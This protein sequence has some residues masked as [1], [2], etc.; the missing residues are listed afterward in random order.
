MESDIA[1]ERSGTEEGESD[2]NDGPYNKSG[3]EKPVSEC[4]LSAAFLP[5]NVGDGE[6]NRGCGKYQRKVEPTER[7]RAGPKHEDAAGCGGWYR[8]QLTTRVK[9]GAQKEKDSRSGIKKLIERG[10]ERPRVNALGDCW[11]E[12]T[13]SHHRPSRSPVKEIGPALK[14]VNVGEEAGHQRGSRQQC[15]CDEAL[16]GQGLGQFSVPITDGSVAT[17]KNS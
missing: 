11:P 15:Q 7:N 1:E 16:V 6:K 3:G 14:L 4:F 10:L 8:P 2:S 12:V 5:E 17:Y 9:L 13:E